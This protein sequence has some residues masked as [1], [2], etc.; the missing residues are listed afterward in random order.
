MDIVTG[1]Y[2]AIPLALVA[3]GS[4]AGAGGNTNDGASVVGESNRKSD[5]RPIF[6]GQAR[7]RA[8]VH[9]D[10]PLA[11]ELELDAVNGILHALWQ[12]GYL[13]RVIREEGLDER[14]NSDPLVRGLLS[15]RLADVTLPLPPTVWLP[16]GTVPGSGQPRF[17][18]GVEA[19]LRIRDRDLYTPARVFGV[20]GLDFRGAA[21]ANAASPRLVAD[22]TLDDLALTCTPE[23]GVLA[24]CYSDLVRSMRQR[25]GDLHGLLTERFT[26]LLSDLILDRRIGLADAH[27][28]VDRA[29]VHARGVAPTAVIRV[30]LYGRLHAPPALAPDLQ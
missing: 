17:R 22:L 28:R 13:A 5:I 19:G 20:V 3:P 21:A 8:P 2:A 10:A 15:V 9:T 6:L 4:G 27:F 12:S 29:R 11:V 14:F 7:P 18:L 1:E 16:P 25:A 24:P 26:R 23:P 30:D